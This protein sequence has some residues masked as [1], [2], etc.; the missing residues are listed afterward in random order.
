MI[1]HSFYDL[2]KEDTF[3]WLLKKWIHFDTKYMMPMFKRK[4]VL[5]GTGTGLGSMRSDK[6]FAS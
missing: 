5:S 3:P 6:K 1:D 2:I 4:T